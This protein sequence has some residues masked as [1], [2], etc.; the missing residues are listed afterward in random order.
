MDKGIPVVEPLNTNYFSVANI[1]ERY[2]SGYDRERWIANCLRILSLIVMVMLHA[3]EGL[4]G[5]LYT[6]SGFEQEA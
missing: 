5:I 6:G 2:F 4:S 1:P 3:D